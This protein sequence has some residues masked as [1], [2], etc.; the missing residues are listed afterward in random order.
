V[1]RQITRAAKRGE[2]R[3]VAH[4]LG[5]L[6]ACLPAGAAPAVDARCA[7]RLPTRAPRP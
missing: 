3:R 2:A 5:T 1:R 4:G 6:P 7:R